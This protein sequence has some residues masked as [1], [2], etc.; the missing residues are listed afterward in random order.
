MSFCSG[1]VIQKDLV[2]QKKYHS[3]SDLLSD[4]NRAKSIITASRY[5][6][7]EFL[8]PGSAALQNG[9]EDFS[10]LFYI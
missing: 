8:P 3:S 1:I 7:Y 5:H 10:F 2:M 4:I 9:S 6:F